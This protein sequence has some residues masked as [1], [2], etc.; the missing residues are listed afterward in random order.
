MQCLSV[1]NYSDGLCVVLKL[2]KLDKHQT[3]LIINRVMIATALYK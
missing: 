3:R 1:G 2:L